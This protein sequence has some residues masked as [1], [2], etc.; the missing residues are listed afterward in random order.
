MYSRETWLITDNSRL[1]ICRGPR[2]LLSLSFA[3]SLDMN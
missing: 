3:S 2:S 1:K